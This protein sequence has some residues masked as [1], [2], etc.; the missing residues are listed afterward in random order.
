MED[1]HHKA[2]IVC[3]SLFMFG[4]AT[5]YG[6]YFDD[7]VF[8]SGMWQQQMLA[9]NVERID[10]IDKLVGQDLPSDG[11]YS[12]TGGWL[13]SEL[14]AEETWEGNERRKWE[15]WAKMH[16]NNVIWFDTSACLDAKHISG[17]NNPNGSPDYFKVDTW[18]ATY[19]SLAITND[20]DYD[21]IDLY[22][23]FRRAWFEMI[24]D[25]DVDCQARG[26]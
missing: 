9:G 15:N 22:R 14:Y 25:C 2:K 12:A 4:V 16:N 11:Y 26:S 8:R 20:Y 1:K 10:F 21:D 6:G 24:E 3:L 19:A 13:S 23:D 5:T 7:L 18:K 17:V